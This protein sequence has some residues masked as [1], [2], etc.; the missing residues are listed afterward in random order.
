MITYENQ[1]GRK[2][3][4][5]RSWEIDVRLDGKIVGEIRGCA[6]GYFYK[7]TGRKGGEVMSTVG[8]VKRSLEAD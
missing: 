2:I 7:P 5:K 4:G 3:S 6:G 8:E 1:N